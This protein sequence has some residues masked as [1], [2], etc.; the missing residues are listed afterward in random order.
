MDTAFLEKWELVVR[1]RTFLVQNE[2]IL[3]NL[4]TYGVHKHQLLTTSVDQCGEIVVATSQFRRDITDNGFLD[5]FQQEL[6]QK[7]S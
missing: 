2:V 4:L 6:F 5:T 3:L 7:V 1:Y